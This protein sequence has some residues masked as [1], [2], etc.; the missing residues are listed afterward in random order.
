[1]DTCAVY[2]IGAEEAPVKI[3]FAVDPHE[4]LATLQTGCPDEL[5]IHATATVPYHRA[6]RIEAETH[7]R[8]GDKCRRGE[9]FN[10]NVEEALEI[11]QAVSD[12]IGA[13]EVEAADR[14]GDVLAVLKAR[15]Y[16]E[17]RFE[18]AVRFYRDAMNH[19]MKSR[20][21]ARADAW[22][23]K[24][25]GQVPYSVFKLVIAEGA[26]IQMAFWGKG[27]DLRNAAEEKLA[28]AVNALTEF[29]A[30]VNRAAFPRI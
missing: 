3:G 22:I 13:E 16:M 2:V 19:P 11:I 15:F 21:V 14:S 7:R 9:W 6:R 5:R 4:R 29:R 1:M 26:N 10:V 24:R 28:A 18:E 12:E 23:L 27:D 8:L 17:P 20:L 25:C 30:K